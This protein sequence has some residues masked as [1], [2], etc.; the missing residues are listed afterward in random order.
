MAFPEGRHSGIAVAGNVALEASGEAAF[1]KPVPIAVS[2]NRQV[3]MEKRESC[4]H[5][6]RYGQVKRAKV[7]GRPDRS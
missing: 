5:P 6:K 1:P 7:G 3:K 4:N 2:R